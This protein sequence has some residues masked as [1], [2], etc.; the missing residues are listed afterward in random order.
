MNKQNWLKRLGWLKKVAIVVLVA[1]IAGIVIFAILRSD[2]F[3]PN[4][5]LETIA[6]IF[7][8]TTA[9]LLIIFLMWRTGFFTI[10]KESE[11]KVVV[12]FE[13]FH[14]IIFT[15]KN[16]FL[17][18]EGN[19]TEGN[20]RK[21]NI[22]GL[23]GIHW[24]GIPPF[25][26]IYRK[27]TSWTSREIDTDEKGRSISKDVTKKK[28]SVDAILIRFDV[29]SHTILKAECSGN[30]PLDVTYIINS[31]CKNPYKAL[32]L[33]EHWEEAVFGALDQ[34]LRDYIG[35][36]TY[37]DL[38]SKEASKKVEGLFSWLEERGIISD[39]EN[40][41]GI[42]V[43]SCDIIEINPDEKFIEV[44]TEKY[45]AEQKAIAA[46]Y[47]AEAITKLGTAEADAV[48]AMAMAINQPGGREAAQ[49]R[50]LKALAEGKNNTV[51]IGDG[52]KN[53]PGLILPT[54]TSG[55]TEKTELG[56]EE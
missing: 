27:K 30:V 47:Q 29:Y 6:M 12:K 50:G 21:T 40:H 52:V 11:A 9:P 4:S 23:G 10:V 20:G 26:Q 45:R 25:Y 18:D 28:V 41:Y 15:D 56:T 8:L 5:L 22:W 16:R 53:A 7:S 46:K 31:R 19:I 1:L 42:E 33:I 24:V 44:S 38:I 48:T 2:V 43:R 3:S 34:S 17:D 55:K 39:I 37:D 13:S 14:K 49:L 32:F 36:K 35:T 54:P 51:F